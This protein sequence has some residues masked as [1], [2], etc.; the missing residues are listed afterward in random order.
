M[1]TVSA[2]IYANAS[3]TAIANAT[4]VIPKATNETMLE[5]Y[6]PY[7]LVIFVAAIAFLVAYWLF[8]SRK[9]GPPKRLEMKEFVS[10]YTLKDLRKKIKAVGHSH[11]G[12]INVFNVFPSWVAH[13]YNRI[14]RV[15][16]DYQNLL[17]IEEGK[18]PVL[19]HYFVVVRR[20]ALNFIK[21]WFGRFDVIIV[22]ASV[23][24][25][26]SDYRIDPMTDIDEHNGVWIHTSENMKKAVENVFWK[27]THQE[28]LGIYTDFPRQAAY[29]QPVQSTA[30]EK[31]SKETE[32]EMEKDKRKIRSSG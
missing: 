30:I 32:L 2:P 24:K 20:G 18:E 1:P 21:G 22:E 26:G 13:G 12:A 9:Q 11:I 5:A 10:D 29:L 8:S 31:L 6:W 23:I 28:T 16:Y 25:K 7:I 14:A 15:I 4:K 19:L 17:K 27:T 3:S